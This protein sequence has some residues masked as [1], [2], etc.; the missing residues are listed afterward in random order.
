VIRL[1][2]PSV[3]YDTGDGRR[4]GEICVVAIEAA[5]GGYAEPRW[6]QLLPVPPH[7]GVAEAQAVYPQIQLTDR[8]RMGGGELD[9][10]AECAQL[11]DLPQ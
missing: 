2:H 9:Q 6:R 11:A 3:P 10:R 1:A 5:H 8:C 7:G 4:E